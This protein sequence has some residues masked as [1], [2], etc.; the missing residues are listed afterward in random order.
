MWA[1][2]PGGVEQKPIARKFGDLFQRARLFEEMSRAGNDLQFY[3]AAHPIA[4]P[5]VQLDNDII[6]AA[7]DEQRRRLDFR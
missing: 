6:V 1:S 2:A 4:R 7:D 5:L 3:V